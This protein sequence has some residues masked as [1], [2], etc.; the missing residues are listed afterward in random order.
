MKVETKKPVY[1]DDDDDD[2]D[3]NRSANAVTDW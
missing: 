2:G 3:S 1:N